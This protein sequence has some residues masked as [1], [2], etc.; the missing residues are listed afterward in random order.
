M[1]LLPFE[2]THCGFW[3]HFSEYVQKLAPEDKRDDVYWVLMQLNQAVWHWLAS[4]CDEDEV[5]I[6]AAEVLR[7]V[8]HLDKLTFTLRGFQPL[9]FNPES[10][11]NRPPIQHLYECMSVLNGAGK[12]FKKCIDPSEMVKWE[13]SSD[14]AVEVFAKTMDGLVRIL[15]AYVKVPLRHL[16][17]LHQKTH[18]IVLYLQE[19]NSENGLEHL[20]PMVSPWGGGGEVA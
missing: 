12:E 6:R 13:M 5:R 19:C 16:A 15:R 4:P 11:R 9:L 14:R 10:Y 2:S 17:I 7:F 20:P 3:K 1:A 18:N 8:S